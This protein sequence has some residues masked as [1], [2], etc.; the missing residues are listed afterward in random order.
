MIWMTRK[1]II[2]R[3]AQV[4]L[5]KGEILFVILNIIETK[6]GLMLPLQNQVDMSY[7]ISTNALFLQC[8]LKMAN[9]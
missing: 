8:S 6:K 9:V 1:K 4:N 3:N 5:L 7:V 2:Q